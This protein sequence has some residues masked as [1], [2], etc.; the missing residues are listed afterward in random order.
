[1]KKIRDLELQG[2]RVLIRTDFNVPMN[3][4]GEITD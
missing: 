4:Q 2:K 3:E 1:M